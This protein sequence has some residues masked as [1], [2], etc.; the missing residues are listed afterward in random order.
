MGYFP[1]NMFDV[2]F[3]DDLVKVD[4]SYDADVEGS[5]DSHVGVFAHTAFGGTVSF[6]FEQCCFCSPS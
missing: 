4:V 5:H 1:V 6:R 3:D 2:S